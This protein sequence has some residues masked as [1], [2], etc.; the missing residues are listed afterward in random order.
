MATKELRD[1]SLKLEACMTRLDAAIR[2]M[3]SERETLNHYKQLISSLYA[4]LKRAN[5]LATASGPPTPASSTGSGG[6]GGTGSDV[7]GKM[8]EILSEFQSNQ[9]KL[10]ADVQCASAPPQSVISTPLVPPDPILMDVKSDSM[11][12]AVV[13]EDQSAALRQLRSQL[14]NAKA[15]LEAA[16][17]AKRSAELITLQA[18]NELA[19]VERRHRSESWTSIGIGALAGG[20]IIGLVW[21][22]SSSSRS[23]NP[24]LL[25]PNK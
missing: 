10:M 17:S 25:P 16:Q 24:S 13:N 12:A 8:R 15:E 2:E 21:L 5:E 1:L 14:D 19:E 20:A 7:I 9:P 6:S 22:F 23:T 11:A 4:E 18:Q 3:Q